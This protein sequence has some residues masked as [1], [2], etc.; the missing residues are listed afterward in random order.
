MVF[1]SDAQRKGFFGNRGNVKSDIKP[2]VITNFKSRKINFIHSVK[3]EFKDDLRGSI[4]PDIVR[5]IFTIP[6][7]DFGRQELEIFID[8]CQI[9][10]T[11]KPNLKIAVT[12]TQAPIQLFVK[13]QGDK[14]Y[15]KVF[16]KLSKGLNTNKIEIAGT[17][18]RKIFVKRLND[19]LKKQKID[20][21]QNGGE[22]IIVN[23]KAILNKK[24]LRCPKVG[25][26]KKLRR[27]EELKLIK[28]IKK[29]RE[30]NKG[31]SQKEVML[32]AKKRLD[33]G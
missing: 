24:T 25:E 6:K 23:K 26:I 16:N 1:K 12:N 32:Q 14:N 22:F 29:F 19:E 28:A 31:L 30:Q 27:M 3:K 15:Q 9:Q 8:R 11:T 10:L 2:V 17:K 21:L 18:E 33:K 13:G 7:D 20:I 4:N 5:G